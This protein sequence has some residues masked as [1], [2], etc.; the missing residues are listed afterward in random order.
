MHYECPHCSGHIRLDIAVNRV[1]S[2]AESDLFGDPIPNPSGTKSVSEGVKTLNMFDEFWKA[3]PRKLNKKKA[4]SIWK[5]RKLDR[6]A[7]LIIGDVLER[8][9]HH[10]Q[11]KK[12]KEFI[13]HPTTY[14]TRS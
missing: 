9:E 7:E 8:A 1:L 3:Y 10:A 13:P 6:R 5:S 14:L 4:Q 2:N 12:G 11:W